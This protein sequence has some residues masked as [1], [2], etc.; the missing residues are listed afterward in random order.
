MPNPRRILAQLVVTAATALAI[1]TAQPLFAAEFTAGPA[2][3]AADV[4]VLDEPDTRRVV[5]SFSSAQGREDALASGDRTSIV[6]P[7]P[8]AILTYRFRALVV[9]ARGEP[10]TATEGWTLRLVRDGLTVA[11]LSTARPSLE[12]PRPY[13]VELAAGD[14]LGI[15]AELPAGA[16]AHITIEYEPP[17][18]HGRLPVVVAAT[19][20]RDTDVLGSAEHFTWTAERSGRL[21]ALSGASLVG[22]SSVELMDVDAGTVI[23]RAQAT[24]AFGS[25]AKNRSETVS[26]GVRL[27]AGRSYRLVVTHPQLLPVDLAAA[28]PVAMLVPTH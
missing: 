6:V 25:A 3:A 28:V 15:I 18:D 2:R 1:S 14:R 4:V 27:T 7:M 8:R 13:G 22:A 19:A 23:W 24:T 21:V 16:S 10:L 17:T 26:V 12:I 11:R 9:D 5:V 20:E